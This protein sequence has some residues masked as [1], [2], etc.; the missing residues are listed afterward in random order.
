MI[1]PPVAENRLQPTS[2]SPDMDWYIIMLWIFSG[3]VVGAGHISGNSAV[4]RA[5]VFASNHYCPR[6][7]GIQGRVLTLIAAV[8]YTAGAAAAGGIGA[9]RD[10]HGA[11]ALSERMAGGAPAVLTVRLEAWWC[12]RQPSGCRP[13]YPSGGD[14]GVDIFTVVPV[15]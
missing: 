5:T 4:V 10:V 3:V 2:A 7:C 1:D 14:D 11:A 8:E 13:N 6:I 12:R 15:P 9:A